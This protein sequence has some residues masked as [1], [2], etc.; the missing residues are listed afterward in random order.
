MNGSIL[1]SGVLVVAFVLVGAGCSGDQPATNTNPGTVAN[2]TNINVANNNAG[3]ANAAAEKREYPAEVAEEFMKSCE[4]S[5]SPQGFCTC[6]FEKVQQEYTFEEF[7][8]IETKLNAGEPPDDFVEF[9][10]KARAAC[11]K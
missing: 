1:S 2:T 9:T 10:G 7:S 5:G 3:N 4:E 8:T 11:T 6:M